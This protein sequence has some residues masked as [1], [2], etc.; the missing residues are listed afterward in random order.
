MELCFNCSTNLHDVTP[1][2]SEA[3]VFIA[4]YL[5]GLLFGPEDGGNGQYD[6]IRSRDSSAGI[7]N[8]CWLEVRI[9]ISDRDK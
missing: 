5:I 7:E 8:G 9:S 1:K 6:V 3:A 2:N 4:G